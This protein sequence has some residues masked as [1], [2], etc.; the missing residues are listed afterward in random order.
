MSAEN[1]SHE[2]E[3]IEANESFLTR[4]PGW[5]VSMVVH[6]C[7]LLVMALV[8]MDT[9]VNRQVA[10]LVSTPDDNTVIEDE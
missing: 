10:D 9:K 2:V 6:T 3:Y 8:T 1:E 7:L 4:V 5:L